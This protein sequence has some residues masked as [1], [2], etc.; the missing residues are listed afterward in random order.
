MAPDVRV[1]RAIVVMS[2]YLVDEVSFSGRSAPPRPRPSRTLCLFRRA[3]MAGQVGRRDAPARQDPPDAGHCGSRFVA[4]ADRGA[5][6]ER[7]GDERRD[8][9]G[10]RPIA[11]ATDDD[12]SHAHWLRL[13]RRAGRK[14]RP[15]FRAMV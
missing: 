6:E 13:L 5:G 7:G 15:A 12:D 3:A 2:D 4:A 1:R 14:F 8:R 9:A 10:E 11:R